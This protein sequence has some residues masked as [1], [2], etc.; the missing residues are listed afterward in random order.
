MRLIFRL[1]VVGLCALCL[2]CESTKEAYNSGGNHVRLI[3]TTPATRPDWLN[4]VPTPDGGGYYFVGTA[5]LS[6]SEDMAKDRAVGD[7]LKN[8]VAFAGV[9]VSSVSER[10]SEAKFKASESSDPSIVENE[11]VLQIA[12]AHFSRFQ[13]TQWYI[14]R[15]GRIHK[16]RVSISLFRASVLLVIPTD[17]IDHAVQD[18]RKRYSTAPEER[19]SIEE[20]KSAEGELFSRI[21]KLRDV[22]T[23]SEKNEHLRIE[24]ERLERKA[25]QL[26]NKVGAPTPK[27]SED[28]ERLRRE[29]D[30]IVNEVRII[31]PSQ[32]LYERASKDIEVTQKTEDLKEKY[33]EEAI[34]TIQDVALYAARSLYNIEL[35]QP[36]LLS[37]NHVAKTVN[38]RIPVTI[39]YNVETIKK[40]KELLS[41]VAKRKTVPDNRNRRVLF[42]QLADP[43]QYENTAAFGKAL[44]SA[45]SLGAVDL[46]EN[47]KIWIRLHPESISAWKSY[48]SDGMFFK[49]YAKM[50]LYNTDGLQIAESFYVFGSSVNVDP[51]DYT[52]EYYNFGVA[53]TILNDPKSGEA[54]IIFEDIP[55][56]T[57]KNIKEARVISRAYYHDG[58]WV[59][60]E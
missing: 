32:S 39:Q 49:Q 30:L 58:K 26:E 27:T 37:T 21:Q 45:A 11:R 29:L 19:V 43:K 31:F 34:T 8:A 51:D 22:M 23:Q 17:E 42:S 13:P 56:E 12:R 52:D 14:E 59:G 60:I 46:F 6:E 57:L 10:L 47:D 48:Y 15:F 53:T 44:I 41:R 54:E 40:M 9:N 4:I 38:V 20:L 1:V 35:G 36:E 5:E 18:S 25:K 50:A 55:L 33:K 24:T 16:R 7:A 28:L 2:A 3:E